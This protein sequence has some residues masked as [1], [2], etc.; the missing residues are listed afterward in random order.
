MAECLKH[1]KKFYET[2]VCMLRLKLDETRSPAHLCKALLIKSNRATVRLETKLLESLLFK[3]LGRADQQY[4]SSFEKDP[5]DIDD[6]HINLKSALEDDMNVN[7][8]DRFD[9]FDSYSLKE[10]IG[11]EWRE[12]FGNASK[13]LVELSTFETSVA[14]NHQS[15]RGRVC[16]CILINIL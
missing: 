1:Y 15:L 10:S 3:V 16:I 8:D 7:D 6:E 12:A 5:D 11:L 14:L 2:F 4:R 9:Y 13:L